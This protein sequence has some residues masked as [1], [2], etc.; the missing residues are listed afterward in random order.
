M[1]T[2]GRIL[3]QLFLSGP[4]GIFYPVWNLWR[5]HAAPTQKIEE[6]R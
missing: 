2:L 1:R 5:M 4:L 6:A 3:V